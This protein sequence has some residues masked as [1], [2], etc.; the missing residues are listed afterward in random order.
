MNSA[1][2]RS[3]GATS[4][5]IRSLLSLAAPVVAVQVGM[6]LMGTVDVMMLGRLDATAL[7]AGALGN[8]VGIGILMFPFGI[9]MA[10]DP[11]V[12]QA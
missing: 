11:M 1:V 2:E 12:S 6:M 4:R 8:A 10:L 3:E 7:A 9:L 5:E